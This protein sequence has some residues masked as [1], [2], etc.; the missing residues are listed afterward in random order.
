MAEWALLSGGMT[1]PKVRRW[2]EQ[3]GVKGLGGE[4]SWLRM[5]VRDPGI[6]HLGG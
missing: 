1:F 2:A 6:R 5:L 4:L 3:V